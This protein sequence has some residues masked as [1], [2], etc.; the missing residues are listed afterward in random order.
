MLLF[1]Q[2]ISIT[3]GF[4]CFFSN[5]T[6]SILFPAALFRL[7]I[8]LCFLYFLLHANSGFSFLSPSLNLCSWGDFYHQHLFELSSLPCWML[9]H[10]YVLSFM[11]AQNLFFYPI[12]YYPP[13]SLNPSPFSFECY[14]SPHLIPPLLV[15]HVSAPFSIMVRHWLVGPSCRDCRSRKL[16]AP[17]LLILPPYLERYSHSNLF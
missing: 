15:S 2:C 10:L 3:W 16:G 12:C 17:I 14:L 4:L 8:V 11:L 6:S 7:D 13:P 1:S 9:A 5:S